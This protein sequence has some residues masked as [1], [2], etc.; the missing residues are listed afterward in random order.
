[1]DDTDIMG[2]QEQIQSCHVH[3]DAEDGGPA[4]SRTVLVQIRRWKSELIG[5]PD[6][7]L[8]RQYL[9]IPLELPVNKRNN[10]YRRLCGSRKQSNLEWGGQ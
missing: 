1:M 10:N 8:D 9:C 7:K 3:V 5:V 4:H 6:R 2:K